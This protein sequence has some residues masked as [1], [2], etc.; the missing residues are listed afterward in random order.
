METAKKTSYPEVFDHWDRRFDLRAAKVVKTILKKIWGDLGM[1]K[2]FVYL[3]PDFRKA[4]WPDPIAENSYTDETNI[5]ALQEK[6]QE[7]ARIP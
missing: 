3:R 1:Q 6:T 5:S 2:L 7:Q 4:S